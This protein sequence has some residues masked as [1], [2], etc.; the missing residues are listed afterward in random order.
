MGNVSMGWSLDG[1]V[2]LT[3][4]SSDKPEKVEQVLVHLKNVSP[5]STTIPGSNGLVK[6]EYRRFK[7]KAQTLDGMASFYNVPVN[8]SYTVT[9][10]H[11]SYVEAFENPLEV[12]GIWNDVD[13]SLLRNEIS[14]I[15]NMPY[16]LDVKASYQREN[17]ANPSMKQ[18][19]EVVFQVSFR[20]P[21]AE[22][23]KSKL[24]LLLKN[25]RTGVVSH[26]EKDLVILAS[27]RNGQISFGHTPDDSGDYYFAAG[28]Y[29][30]QR[31]NEFSDCWDWSENPLFYVTKEHRT[32]E[33][34]GYTWDVKAGFGNPGQN[35]WANDS[36]NVWID[37]K[38]RLNLT[39][40]PDDNGR[41]YAT[42]VISRDTFGYGVYT[43]YI[44]AEP[45]D[46]DPHVVAGIFLYRDEENE[47]DIEFSRWGDK[48]NYQFGNYVVQPADLPGNQFRFPIL[49]SG[50]YTTHRIEWNPDQILFSSWHGHY[51]EPPV[52]KIIA[53]WQYGGY[54]IPQADQIKLFFNI[55][56]FRGIL[57]KS[58]K[59]EIFTIA[60]FT[61][62]PLPTPEDSNH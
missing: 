27:E 35:F 16:I 2:N 46:F 15:R 7:E 13:I 42:E 52:G 55:W 62:V 21:S 20:N 31:I 24:I 41:W 40:A 6:L 57:P 53:Q 19:D 44:D 37:G 33:F 5:G 1:P 29:L 60:R 49:A 48:E 26:I 17:L 30:K 51:P 43:F 32:I 18:G 58:D 4:N 54:S 45:Q 11:Q 47:I 10:L 8:N 25:S 3:D 34:A 14:F 9:G 36:S 12:W 38:E 22:S 28:V 61:Y 59:S 23:Y 56:L 50:S 39:L